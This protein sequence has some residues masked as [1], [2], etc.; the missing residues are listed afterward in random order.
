MSSIAKSHIYDSYYYI[1]YKSYES[2]VIENIPGISIYL[3]LI[4]LESNNSLLLSCQL[5]VTVT[6]CFVY[7]IIRY[8]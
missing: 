3:I 2:N 8:L 4:K 6:S 7:K 1:L 5:R